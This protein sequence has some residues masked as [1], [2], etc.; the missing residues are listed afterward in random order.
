[1]EHDTSSNEFSSFLVSKNIMYYNY[2]ISKKEVD[3]NKL[4]IRQ[5][6]FSYLKETLKW[7]TI[8][9]FFKI[10]GQSAFVCK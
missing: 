3:E 6:I 7:N 8:Y 1:M 9:K 2:F 10:A 4:T 5:K